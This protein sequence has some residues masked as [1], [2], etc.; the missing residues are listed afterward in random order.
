MGIMMGAMA[1][2]P[3]MAACHAQYFAVFA[4]FHCFSS[5]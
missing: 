4:V 5:F 1:V 2:E 3:V